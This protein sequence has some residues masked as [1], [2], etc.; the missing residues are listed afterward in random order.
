MSVTAS[1]PLV[2]AELML[3]FV[4]EAEVNCRPAAPLREVVYMKVYSLRFSLTFR[5]SLS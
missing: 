5:A 4:S 1:P 3:N 2:M